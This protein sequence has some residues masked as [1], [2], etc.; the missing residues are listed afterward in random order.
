[1]TTFDPDTLAQDHGV[2]RRI[3]TDFE[4]AIALDAF[5]VEPGTVDVGDPVHVLE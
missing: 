4:G 2:L 5:V 1:M 3:I